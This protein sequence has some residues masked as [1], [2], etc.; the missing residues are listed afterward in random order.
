MYEERVD[1]ARSFSI[2]VSDAIF[3]RTRASMKN[4][5]SAAVA[6]IILLA[7]SLACSRAGSNVANSNKPAEPANAAV[8]A[9]PEISAK[10]ARLESYAIKG[11]KFAYY[12]IPAGLKKDELIDT[13]QKLHDLEPD[14]QIIMV[15]DDSQLAD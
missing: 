10:P 13:A 15:D 4:M 9:K 8:P 7:V 3:D 6:I 14:T 1:K 2:A 12:R 11:I 5:S